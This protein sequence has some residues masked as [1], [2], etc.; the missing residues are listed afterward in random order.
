MIYNQEGYPI[1][2]LANLQLLFFSMKNRPFLPKNP[3]YLCV[4][5][6]LK[7]SKGVFS[8]KSAFFTMMFI[9]P[10]WPQK[11]GFS[12]SSFCLNFLFAKIWLLSLKPVLCFFYNYA[13]NM[14]AIFLKIVPV[15]RV[16]WY[17]HMISEQFFIWKSLWYWFR[18]NRKKWSKLIRKTKFELSLISS[19]ASPVFELV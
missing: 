12:H 19:S 18:W 17:L 9:I 4:W 10:K 16:L 6:I 8:P 7:T 5:R 1:A 13:L 15:D 14:H 11:C 3:L 2:F